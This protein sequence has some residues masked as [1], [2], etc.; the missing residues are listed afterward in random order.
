M[1]IKQIF[2]VSLF[3]YTAAVA[4]IAQCRPPSFHKGRNFIN[5]TG[6]GL[7]YVAVQPKDLSLTSLVCLGTSLRSQHPNWSDASILVFTD[8]IAAYNFDPSGVD[9]ND[10]AAERKWAAELHASYCFN[11]NQREEFLEIMPLGYKGPPSLDSRIDLPLGDKPPHCSLELDGRCIF[12]AGTIGYPGEAVKE[13]ISGSVTLHAKVTSSGAIRA[14]H[15]VKS[16]IHPRQKTPVLANAAIHSLSKWRL[17]PASHESS[18][19]IT[20]SYEIGNPSETRTQSNVEFK[21]PNQII[22]R[23]KSVE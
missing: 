20:Y 15:V 9:F 2:S 19:R 1:K 16:D 4:A 10:S 21:L 12:D 7:L 23:G 5:D 22:I 17:D 3:I 8:K 18:V 6:V 14:I 11:A 13:K